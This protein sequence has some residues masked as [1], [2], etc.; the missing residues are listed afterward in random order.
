MK[1]FL[2]SMLLSGITLLSI[3]AESATPA[4]ERFKTLEQRATKIRKT[5][6][7]K[8]V[9]ELLGEPVRKGTRPWEPDNPNLWTYLDSTDETEHLFFA[10]DVGAK[11]TQKVQSRRLLRSEITKGQKVV[12]TGTIRCGDESHDLRE[13]P[14]RPADH[15]TFKVKMDGEKFLDPSYL[16]FE[17]TEGSRAGM[18]GA[19]ETRMHG[20]PEVG[21]RFH[22][23]VYEGWQPHLQDWLFMGRSALYLDSIRFEPSATASVPPAERFK[24]LQLLAATLLPTN[25][26][27]EVLAILG[28]P[29]QKGISPWAGIRPGYWTYL[30]YADDEESFSFAVDNL[31]GGG[32]KV[33]ATHR[34]RSEIAKG[35][36]IIETGVILPR[37]HPLPEIGMGSVLARL[38]GGMT[39][40]YVFD[41]TPATKSR[42]RGTPEAGGRFRLEK[43]AGAIEAGLDPWK[44]IG[45]GMMFLDSIQ[46]EPAARDAENPEAKKKDE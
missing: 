34:Q 43:F 33:K 13:F 32:V 10:V 42:Y 8:Q 35:K 17:M 37:A 1:V 29:I 24:T 46:F 41:I 39:L 4:A 7:A 45:G 15:W 3:R 40:A 12:Y 31:E 16:Y 25:N 20:T 28:E 44:F 19:T 38:D 5:D 11:A 30:N 36:K 6:R 2:V 14:A 23:E 21:G 22:L 27:E 18:R 26:P 9:K